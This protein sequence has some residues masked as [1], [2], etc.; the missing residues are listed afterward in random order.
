MELD[1]GATILVADGACISHTRP[2]GAT[3]ESMVT[4]G[5]QLSD[6]IGSQRHARALIIDEARLEEGKGRKGGGGGAS[7]SFS[8]ED[9]GTINKPEMSLEWRRRGR[10]RQDESPAHCTVSPGGQY[11]QISAFIICQTKVIV[12][13][14]RSNQSIVKAEQSIAN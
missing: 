9:N 1:C 5:S 14:K 10:C 3:M 6:C 7:S 13:R 12:S 4:L 8:F 2:H 11:H